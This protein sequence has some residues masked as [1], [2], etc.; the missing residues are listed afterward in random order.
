MDLKKLTPGEITTAVCGVLLFI[1]SFFPWYGVDLGPFGS[2]NYSAWKQPDSFFS[3]VAVLL[4]VI[5]AAHV[6]IEKIEAVDLP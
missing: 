1:V 5:L 3:I 4:G 6:I 2:Y